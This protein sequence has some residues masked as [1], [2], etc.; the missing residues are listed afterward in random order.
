MRKKERKRK[1]VIGF[2]TSYGNLFVFQYWNDT[3]AEIAQKWADQCPT[4]HDYLRARNIPGKRT[5]N[6]FKKREKKNTT[7]CFY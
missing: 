1:F 2:V 3:L 7:N 5:A 6:V 4:D